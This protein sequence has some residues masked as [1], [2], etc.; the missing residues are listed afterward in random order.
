MPWLLIKAAHVAVV[1]ASCT[2]KMPAEAGGTPSLG[3]GREHQTPARAD[4]LHGCWA[5]LALGTHPHPQAPSL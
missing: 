4:A 3:D 5:V 1:M 2:A